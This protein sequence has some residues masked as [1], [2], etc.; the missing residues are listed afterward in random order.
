MDIMPTL[1]DVANTEYPMELGNIETLSLH[2]K[3]LL[4]ILK[5][6]QR[7]KPDFF[8]SGFTNNFRM[9][10]KGDW[11]LV[12]ANGEDWE[13]YNLTNDRTEMNNLADSLP[14]KVEELAKRYE[15]DKNNLLKKPVL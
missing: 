2:G 3:S 10:R 5:G 13:S 11:K 1:I 4:P 8:I 14:S 9:Y 7:E 6:E 12:K 15:E